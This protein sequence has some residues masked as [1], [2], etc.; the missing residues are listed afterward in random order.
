M[1]IPLKSLYREPFQGLSKKG[2]FNCFIEKTR[3]RQLLMKKKY[4]KGANCSR[5]FWNTLY[6]RD[7]RKGLRQKLSSEKSIK[8]N[9]C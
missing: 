3:G 1:H 5:I 7:A 8:Y 9:F 4:L 2:C 6:C